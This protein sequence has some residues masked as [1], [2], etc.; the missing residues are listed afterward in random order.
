MENMKVAIH[1]T[2]EA[3]GKQ[4][5]RIEC[6]DEM[7]FHHIYEKFLTI[8]PLISENSIF[9]TTK[10]LI[11]GAN[12]ISDLEKLAEELLKTNNIQY[13]D[14]FNSVLKVKNDVHSN[15]K[16]FSNYRIFK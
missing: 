4:G 3:Q 1:L 14:F 8:Q 2:E 5:I 15:E 9:K 7:V 11:I 16:D 10:R 13:R 6:E 12:Y